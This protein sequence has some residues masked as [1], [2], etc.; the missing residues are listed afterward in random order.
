MD[1]FS[2]FMPIA[3]KISDVAIDWQQVASGAAAFAVIV[4]VSFLLFLGL[5]SFLRFHH[6]IASERNM[7]NMDPTNAFYIRIVRRIANL[8]LN[9]KPFCLVLVSARLRPV[10]GEAGFRPADREAVLEKLVSNLRSGD[11]RAIYNDDLIAL[12]IEVGPKNMAS[13]QQRL[14]KEID[15]MQIAGDDATAHKVDLRMGCAFFPEGAESIDD[16]FSNAQTMLAEARAADTMNTWKFDLDLPDPEAEVEEED[17]ENLPAYIDPVTGLLKSQRAPA[18]AQKFIS[19]YRRDRNAVSIILISIDAPERYAKNYGEGVVGALR[20]EMA[21]RMESCLREE[22]LLCCW[23]EEGFVV[24]IDGDAEC[25]SLV[26]RRLLKAFQS[27]K[28]AYG[29]Y[30]LRLKT[31]LGSAS[32]PDHKDLPREILKA[33]EMALQSAGR[34]GGNIHVSFDPKLEQLEN[35]RKQREAF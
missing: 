6:M 25:A 16:L 17:D 27:D 19:Q 22:D 21:K 32:Y 23:D 14:A 13:V 5:A 33:A 29:G 9:A 2:F 15:Q 3:L 7:E 1:L 12:A 8:R 35:E 10:A 26:A 18:T 34:K 28:V 20:K 4:A 11:D 24:G 31:T 30:R